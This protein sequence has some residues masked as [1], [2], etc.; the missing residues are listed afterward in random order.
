MLRAPSL[1][2]TLPP[3]SRC[4]VGV[5]SASALALTLG[6]C[7][8][9]LRR[10]EY[11]RPAMGTEFRLRFYAADRA[12]AEAAAE[13][14]F[15]RIAD[16]DRALSDYDERSE[17]ARLGRGSDG[18]DA[19]T[20]VAVSEDLFAVLARGSEIAEASAGAFDPTAGRFTQLWRRARRQGERPAPQHLAEAAEAVGFRKY[21]LDPAG[22]RVRL[23]ARGMRFDLGGIAKGFALDQALTTLS[24]HGIE[25]ALVDGGGDLAARA[26]P[27]GEP[28]WR[29]S[30]AG[31]D[32]PDPASDRAAQ[33]L[34]LTRAALATSGD[35]ERSIVLDGQRYSHV[36]DPRTGEALRTRRLVSVLAPDGSSADAW[37]TALSVLEPGPGLEALAREPALAARIVR[38]GP[39]GLELFVSPGFPAPLSCPGSVPLS[40]SAGPEPRRP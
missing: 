3:V 11:A 16:L 19:P 31:L 38:I 18:Q 30:I 28:G 14:A 5:L 6:S 34:W 13:A 37:A 40:A 12:Q 25:R 26:P 9:A 32:S 36:I 1:L 21:E 35:L 39:D 27:P 2:D 7:R 15:E 23:L 4:L 29:V 33:G 24:A 8:A 17:L 10:Y 20:W 22:R